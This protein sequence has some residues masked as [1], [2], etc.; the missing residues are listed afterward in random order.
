M[1]FQVLSEGG[2][3]PCHGAASSKPAS[4]GSHFPVKEQIPCTSSSIC[5][6]ATQQT[7]QLPPQCM[8][9]SAHHHCCYVLPSLIC[10]K[11]FIIVSK[12]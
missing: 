6:E 9:L 1:R 12:A 5:S 3:R 2:R 10:R 8:P 4:C 11:P 7:L